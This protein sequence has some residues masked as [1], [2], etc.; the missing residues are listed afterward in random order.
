MIDTMFWPF[1]L[2]AAADRLNTLHLNPDGTTPES[3][4]HGVE[5]EE[6]PVKN[7]HTLF[8]PVYVLDHR[9]HDAGSLGPP[10]WDPCSRVGVYLGHSPFHAGSVALVFNIKTGRVSP[11]Y[12][13][14]FD[15]D[16]T[17]VPFMER[18]EEPSNWADLCQHLSESYIDEAVTLAEDWLH[19]GSLDPTRLANVSTGRSTI[20]EEEPASMQSPFSPVPSVGKPDPT[21]EA[22]ECVLTPVLPPNSNSTQRQCRIDGSGISSPGQC[23]PG[24]CTTTQGKTSVGTHRGGP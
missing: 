2:L 7:F 19:Q 11:Q 12:H 13:V 22:G 17:T 14:V 5:L 21:A 4:L 1:A 16:F 10:K 18:G 20:L 9:L 6:L 24:P 8:C 15:S 23:P 3:K